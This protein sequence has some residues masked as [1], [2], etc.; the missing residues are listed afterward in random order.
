MGE[1]SR[2]PSNRT[3]EAVTTTT[4]CGRERISRRSV[5]E[6]GGFAGGGSI[7]VSGGGSEVRSGGRGSICGFVKTRRKAF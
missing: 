5:S 4:E 3:L 1:S 7:S 6:S 2:A